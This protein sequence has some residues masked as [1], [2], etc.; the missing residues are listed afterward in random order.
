MLINGLNLGRKNL[1]E[2]KWYVLMSV[3]KDEVLKEARKTSLILTMVGVTSGVVVV[4]IVIFSLRIL[5]TKRM[6]YKKI[7]KKLLWMR[8]TMLPGRAE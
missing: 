6:V 1:P 4:L 5:I 2:E 3:Y 8:L 7:K